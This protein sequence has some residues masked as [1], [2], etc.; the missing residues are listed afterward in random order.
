[1]YRH[2]KLSLALF[3]TGRNDAGRLYTC[4]LDGSNI[5]LKPRLQAM[6]LRL[7]ERN[8]VHPFILEIAQR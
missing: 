4:R 2:V 1:M 3:A 6:P 7:K 5:R 8:H